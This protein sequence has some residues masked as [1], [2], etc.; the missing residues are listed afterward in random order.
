MP[1]RNIIIG[2]KIV[3]QKV[4]RARELRTQMTE[5]EKRLWQHLRAKRLGGRHFR[6]QQVIAGFVVDLY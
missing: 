6:R 1:A 3:P 5:A 2:Q 4:E